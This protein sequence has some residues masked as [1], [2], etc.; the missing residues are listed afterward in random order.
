MEEI[1]ED[2]QTRLANIE[3]RL[4]KVSYLVPAEAVDGVAML[5][6]DADWMAALL[7]RSHP[8]PAGTPEVA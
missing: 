1:K 4:E 3:E 6:S 5:K 2:V 7:R 8:K